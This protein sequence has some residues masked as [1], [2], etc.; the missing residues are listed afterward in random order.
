M[1]KQETELGDLFEMVTPKGNKIYMQCVELQLDKKNDVELTKIFYTVY[2]SRPDN[3]NSIIDDGFFF[4]RFPIKAAL[5]KKVIEK[6]GNISLPVDFKKPEYFRTENSFGEGW[7]IV[8]AKTLKRETILNLSEDQKRLSPW[9]MM[10]DTLIIELLE[11]GWTLEK[12]T[13]KNMF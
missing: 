12:W 8:N 1:K 13:L 3:I 4:N 5:S 6:I 9:G 7:Q 11:K 2:K 10:N